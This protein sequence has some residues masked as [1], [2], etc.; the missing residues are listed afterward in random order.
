MN[1]AWRM[2]Q[3]VRKLPTW[4]TDLRTVLDTTKLDGSRVVTDDDIEREREEGMEEALVQQ[5][6]FCNPRAAPRGSVYGQQLAA[7]TDYREAA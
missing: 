3:K 1:H 2:Y 7:Y 4:Y 6:Y 5:E